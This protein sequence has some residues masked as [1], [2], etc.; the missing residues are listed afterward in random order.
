MR[1]VPSELRSGISTLIHFD[2]V[3]DVFSG[4]F[5]STS[6]FSLTLFESELMNSALFN[7]VCD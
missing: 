3:F 7:D 5:L 6:N 4:I 1:Y 2:T